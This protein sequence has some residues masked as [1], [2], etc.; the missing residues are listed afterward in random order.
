M[1]RRTVPFVLL[2]DEDGLRHAVKLSAVQVLSDADGETNSTAIQL[3]GNRVAVI[4]RPLDE[5][6]SWFAWPASSAGQKGSAPTWRCAD[7]YRC[8]KPGRPQPRP[9]EP[10]ALISGYPHPFQDTSKMPNTHHAPSIRSI[11]EP[12]KADRFSCAYAS[13][14]EW[15]IEKHQPDVWFHGHVHPKTPDYEIGRTRVMSNTRGY[16][17]SDLDPA[18][19]PARG[20]VGDEPRPARCVR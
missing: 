18:F 7:R 20:G 15:L 19:D 5:V 13:P 2:L 8:P 16:L 10:S 17:P 4:R 12:L 9:G 6:L 11:P 1:G 3:T 14:L